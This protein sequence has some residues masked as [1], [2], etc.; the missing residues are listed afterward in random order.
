M[1]LEAI[2]Q[3]E[4]L[5]QAVLA[6]QGAMRQAGTLPAPR[7]PEVMPQAAHPRRLRLHQRLQAC[8]AGVEEMPFC[9][10]LRDIRLSVSS[11][12]TC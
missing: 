2:P 5:R 9:S 10:L 3:R 11:F 6:P 4:G 7:L 8:G 12:T 1:R